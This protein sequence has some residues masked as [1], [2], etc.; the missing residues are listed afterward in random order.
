ME[1]F[2]RE[3]VLEDGNIKHHLAAIWNGCEQLDKYMKHVDSFLF[4]SIVEFLLLLK[5]EEEGGTE[6]IIDFWINWAGASTI[7]SWFGLRSYLFIY[8][9]ICLFINIQPI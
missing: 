7:H 9:F 6:Q 8:S 5:K 1:Y 3:I 4:L 2:G